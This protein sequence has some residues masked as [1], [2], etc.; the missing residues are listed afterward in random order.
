MPII[1]HS[2]TGAD[3]C[4]CIIVTVTGTD[5]ELSCNEVRLGRWRHPGWDL[6]RFG[7]AD[8][9]QKLGDR[10]LIGPR[11]FMAIVDTEHWLIAADIRPLKYVGAAVALITLAFL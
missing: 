2:A 3:C 8:T 7:L 6:G 9:G 10:Y 5:A 1:P 4:G 11:Y